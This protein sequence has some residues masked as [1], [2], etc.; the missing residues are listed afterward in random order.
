MRTKIF[1][2]AGAAVMSA[3]LLLNTALYSTAAVT[4]ADEPIKFE[5]ENAEIT[6][7]ISV[8]KDSNASG[9][10]VLK[11]T[12]DGTITVKLTVEEGGPYKLTFYA[13]GIGT[14]KQQN[15]SVNGSSQGAIGIP[16]GTEYQ[17]VELTAIPLKAGENT[18]VIEKSWGWS[19]F[20]YLT[21]E[22]MSGAK[23][24]AKQI[25]PC[26]QL[27]TVETQ[28]LM[29]YLADNYGKHIISGQQEIYSGGPH[30]L[31]T[32]FEYL[33]DTT[34]HYPAIR[35]FDY[36]NFCCPLYGSDDGSTDRVI[37]WVKNKG[38]IATASYHLNVPKDFASYTIG[39]K[40]DWAQSTYT[41]KDTD[42]SP[43][44]A[45]TAGTKENEYYLSTLKT[46]AKEFNKLE[47][48]G[49][50]VIW[51]PLHEAE[52]GGGENGSW[53]WWGREGSAAYKK[54][55]QYTYNTLT[56]DL[57][58]H[59][60]IWEWNSYNFATSKDWYPGDNYVDIIGY[61]KYSCTDWSTGS[62]RYYHNDSPFS[63]TF[64]GIMEKY[65]SAKMIS[66]AENDSFSTPD[67]LQE[68]KAGWLYFCTW[69]DGG[70]D[71]NNFLSNPTFNTKEDTIAMY[72]SEYC[73]T[74][75]EL[76]ATLYKKDGVTPP[77][78]SKTTTSTTTATTTADPN[79][80]TTTTAYKF[81]IQKKTVTIPEKPALAVG[82][83]MNI[84]ISGAPNASIGG[85]IGFG[86]T[87]DDWQNIEWKGNADKDG[88][89]TVNVDLKEM[90][91]T[92]KS[93]E[94]Q[95]WWSNVWNAATE[96]AIDQPYTIDSC[97]VNYLMGG[98]LEAVWGDANCDNTVD[99]SDVV[100]IMQALA[101]PNKYGL[102]GTE[103]THIT[104]MGW[105]W[106]DVDTSSEGV[107]ANDA[108]R[109][110][111]YLLKKVAKLDPTAK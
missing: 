80:T 27:A 75:D 102:E 47:A 45:A 51:R 41:A 2:K 4:A 50:P 67:K 10:S 59:N 82:K 95:V 17:P 6:G 24:E 79:A 16:Q 33:K 105:R 91:D 7:T 86:T 108:L 52:G 109:I 23:I 62:A 107:T 39:T 77:D 26:D 98:A 5:F 103:K 81:A 12:E 25:T 57:N 37:D 34:G 92:F 11:M 44:K 66:L 101:N 94:V 61:D 64:Y 19:Q 104:E 58:C 97:K 28:S 74:L 38:G 63:S 49:I 53:F 96:K 46:L 20:D 60:L 87:A 72:Q 55:W 106:A 54:L 30:G 43:S 88:K 40:M 29:A 78:P 21:A 110:Q 84:T 42:F 111:E 35:G 31:E 73:I 18:I 68:E 76:P 48:E 1:K 69:Y 15:L 99:M 8:E 70:S 93:C 9:G 22:P 3:A 89:L 90:P 65:D 83:Q 85:A 71:N 100:L 32:E 13:F 36:G 14:D 56:N